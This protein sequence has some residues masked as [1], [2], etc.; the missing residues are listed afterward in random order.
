MGSIETVT[1][2]VTDL[3]GSTGLES[4]IGP[5]AAE[6]LRGEHFGLLREAISE[7]GGREL[8]NTGDGLTAA[9]DSAAAAFWGAVSVQQRFERRNRSAEEQLLIKV[10]VSSGDA[11]AVDGDY[12]GMPVIEA[13]RLCDRCSGPQ[14]LAKELVAHLAGGRGHTFKAMGALELKG[15]PEPLAAVEVAW[16]PLGVEAGSLPLPA[17][18]Q[19]VPDAGFV[20]RTEEADRLHELFCE[21]VA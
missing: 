21:A 14:I 10:G 15:L 3:V 19:G 4:R 6:G 16:E 12:F 9:F 20:G 17:R 2:L 7:A 18:L 8:K 13:A 11:T 5:A 1:L